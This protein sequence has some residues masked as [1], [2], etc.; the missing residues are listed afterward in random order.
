MGMMQ[1]IYTMPILGIA[2][3]AGALVSRHW[4]SRTPARDDGGAAF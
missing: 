3:V 4:S 1:P 2:I